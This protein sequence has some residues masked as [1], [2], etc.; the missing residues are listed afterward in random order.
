MSASRERTVKITIAGDASKAA[1][2]FKQSID[3]ADRLENKIGALDNAFGKASAGARLLGGA[4]T[5]AGIGIALKALEGVGALFGQFTG[6]LGDAQESLAVA[7][8]LQ[9]VLTSTGGVAGM[10]A[11]S[12]N[13][14]AESLS[15][16]TGIDDEAIVSAQSLLLTFTNVGKEV[17]PEATAAI[18]DL[19][20]ALGQDLKSTSM[21]VGKALNDPIAGIS[22]LTRVGVTFTEQQKAQIEAMVA[23]G[24]TAGAQRIIIAELDRQVG[25][26]AAAQATAAKK[27]QVAW[28]NIRE[29]IGA[30]LLPIF[31]KVAGKLNDV[32]R[33]EGMQR[34]ID[35]LGD[36]IELLW[37]GFERIL[38]PVLRFAT[39]IA[40]GARAVYDAASAFLTG[41]TNLGQFIGGM[42]ILVGRTLGNFGQ[43]GEKI[44][45]ILGA[46][47]TKILD[48]ITAVAPQLGDQL[49]IWGRRFG[50]W[51]TETAWPWLSEKLVELAG[52][53]GAW[54]KDTAL[55]TIVEKAREWGVALGDWIT[56]TAIPWLQEKIPEWLKAYTDWAET[57]GRPAVIEAMKK[58]AKAMGDFI[59]D[60]AIPWLRQKLPEWLRAYETWAEQTARPAIVAAMKKLAA[61]M[62]DWVVNDAIPYL[63]ENLPKWG[64]AIVAWIK[65]PLVPMVFDGA[66][67]IGHAIVDAV[68]AGLK[69]KWQDVVD[70]LLR[71]ASHLPGPVRGV[72]G[73][74]QSRSAAPVAAP[75]YSGGGGGAASGGFEALR[76]PSGLGFSALRAA[77]GGAAGGMVVNLTINAPGL[78]DIGNATQQ[79]ALAANVSRRVWD[80]LVRGGSGSVR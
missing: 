75:A 9:A 54:M 19:S 61:A 74:D 22:A 44:G 68:V 14:L 69:A 76:A 46:F 71:L 60:D 1:P 37:R 34:F 28:G 42:E 56:E 77:P 16:L 32:L 66:K 15:N 78:T 58:F 40:S 26:S 3:D 2:A 47:G 29:E 55:P 35:R 13:D 10:T 38:P 23:V 4:L 59:I 11:E 41:K 18:L 39:G 24:D 25:G 73:L 45:P 27:L 17:F 50:D 72:L 79:S 57:T 52:A 43:L 63:R 64:A 80:E 49:L 12:V 36:G 48:F 65:D 6:S 21:M 5:G 30:R 70:E 67:I 20:V 31:E 53:L 51:V 62:G 8:Q 7:N 33:S